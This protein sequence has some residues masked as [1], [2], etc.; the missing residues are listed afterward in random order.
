MNDLGGLGNEAPSNN[1]G[2][3]TTGNAADAAPSSA[4]PAVVTT[5][6][7]MATTHIVQP[8]ETL[9]SIAT[10]HGLDIETLYSYN[11]GVLDRAAAARGFAH[12]EG[13][14][15]LFT[16]DVVSLVPQNTGG[17]FTGNMS[18]TSAAGE[19]ARYHQLYTAG[20]LTEEEWNAVK[21]KLLP[22]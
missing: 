21:A 18:P 16:G 12:S 2:V 17:P 20:A 10:Q 22:S 19:L 8:E 9:D 13:G 15:I 3:D 14:R 11:A 4:A 7:P 1:S 6:S 5:P